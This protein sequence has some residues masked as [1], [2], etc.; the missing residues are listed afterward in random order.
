[1]M[2]NKEK[3]QILFREAVACRAMIML[4][5]CLFLCVCSEP[6][7]AEANET[8]VDPNLL[9]NLENDLLL[10]KNPTTEPERQLWQAR[11]SV[12]E[13][14]QS[15]QSKDE[16]KNL[17]RKVGAI[18]FDQP[19]AQPQPAP[20]STP[21][22]PAESI[23]PLA[24]EPE[25]GL[26]AEPNEIE[27]DIQTKTGLDERS[28][29]E[30]YISA[31]TLKLFQELLQ[32]PQ[33]LKAPFELAEILFS[34][35]CFN[36]A[37]VCYQVALDRLATDQADPYQDKAWIL[38]QLGNCFQKSDPEKAMGKFRTVV[39]DYS[40]CPWVEVAQAKSKFIDWRL[41]DNPLVLI[42]ECKPVVAVAKKE[43][44]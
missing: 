9:E 39:A 3:Q 40:D 4:C 10:A 8:A 7:R 24:V 11:I 19:E 18:Q 5:V 33:Q 21:E 38:F 28:L 15:D 17:I 31:Q 25:P 22:A 2:T 44:Y 35:D 1:M 13:D 43:S 41:K 42:N 16:L 14:G 23:R 20:S 6:C 34:S 12:S 27:T 36:E 30:G 29:P 32:Q 37:A 26:Q